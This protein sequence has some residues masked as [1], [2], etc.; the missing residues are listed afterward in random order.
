MS[1]GGSSGDLEAGSKAGINLGGRFLDAAEVKLNI[2]VF[3]SNVNE[4]G[5]VRSEEF[6]RMGHWST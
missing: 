5:G 6:D 4:E 3:G 2:A 1:G